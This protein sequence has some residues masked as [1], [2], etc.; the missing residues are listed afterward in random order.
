[1]KIFEQK[2]KFAAL[3]AA[4]VLAVAFAIAVGTF[5]HQAGATPPTGGGSAGSSTN[6]FAVGGISLLDGDHLAFAA[7]LNPKTGAVAGHVVQDAA[8]VSRSGPVTCVTFYN[9]NQATIGWM[10]KN[11][12]NSMEIGTF[13]SFEVTDNGEPVMG[14]S[15]D[16]FLDRMNMDSDCSDMSGG[17]VMPVHGNIV[18]KYSP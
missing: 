13:R 16:S 11:S 4:P 8:T 17:G 6:A 15:P 10:V 7:Q 3:A 1:M 14:V 5:T 9:G 18:V 2:S 12:T